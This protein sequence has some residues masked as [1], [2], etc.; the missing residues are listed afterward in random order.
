ML[1]PWFVSFLFL[2]MIILHKAGNLTFYEYIPLEQTVVS[3]LVAIWSFGLLSLPLALVIWLAF[4]FAYPI[5]AR[6]NC[7]IKYALQNPSKAYNPL[8]MEKRFAAMSRKTLLQEIFQEKEIVCKNV[9]LSGS[10]SLSQRFI[11]VR[12]YL[13]G[14]IAYFL[15]AMIEQTQLT[16]SGFIWL[17]F[18]DNLV[19]FFGLYYAIYMLFYLLNVKLGHNDF[20]FHP[21]LFDLFALL[22]LLVG[23]AAVVAITFL[24]NG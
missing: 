1:L 5:I 13:C 19:T 18:L 23:I 22:F 14:V 8:I 4:Y 7:V 10:G 17:V 6:R 20:Y 11:P 2:I 3:L 24:S 9:N 16:D 21:W 12:I 15:L